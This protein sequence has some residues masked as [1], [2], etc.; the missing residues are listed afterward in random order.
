MGASS[1]VTALSCLHSSS[2]SSCRASADRL[3]LRCLGRALVDES[4]PSPPPVIRTR[5]VERPMPGPASM[6]SLLHPPPTTTQTCPPCPAA[7]HAP[8]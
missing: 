8:P 2:S 1:G 4:D 7:P 5:A 6:S 3:G